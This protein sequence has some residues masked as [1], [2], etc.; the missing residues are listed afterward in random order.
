MSPAS[1]ILDVQYL[2][3]PPDRFSNERGVFS[4]GVDLDDLHAPREARLE[5]AKERW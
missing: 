4:V 3:K 5:C 1:V 2:T